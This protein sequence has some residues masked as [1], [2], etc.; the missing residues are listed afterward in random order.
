MQ[1][2]IRFLPTT[3]VALAL[4]LSTV[5]H[6]Q[7]D[8]QDAG[9]GAA[10]LRAGGWGG[11]PPGEEWQ[12]L[13]PKQKR[14]A[15]R[16]S[17]LQTLR[18]SLSFLGF[19][20]P[21]LL[22]A[23]E[24][25]ALRQDKILAPLRLQERQLVGVL[26]ANALKPEQIGQMNENFKALVEAARTERVRTIADLDAQIGFSKNPRLAAALNL[27]GVTGEDSAFIGGVGTS[28]FSATTNF[29]LG[30]GQT[31]ADNQEEERETQAGVAPPAPQ[32]IRN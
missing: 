14:A 9:K 16:D 15:L 3:L 28:L 18:R 11:L 5:A 12:R 32:I 21:Q 10:P 2:P 8:P 26:M 24:A 4:L 6:A 17:T 13:T 1:L 19:T 20:D 30:A 25:T 23:V 27:A 31:D 22:D 29:M 7:P